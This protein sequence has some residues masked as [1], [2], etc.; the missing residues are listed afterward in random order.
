MGTAHA[1]PITHSRKKKEA[2]KQTIEVD[3]LGVNAAG[4]TNA[5]A[6]IKP[7]AATT[8]RANLALPV[9]LKIK[10]ESEPPVRSPTIPANRG[11]DPQMPS[12]RID[13]WRCSRR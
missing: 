5:L 11:T 10:S 2:A 7:G 13:M 8:R 9:V 1:G 4:T 12:E 6:R 3:V